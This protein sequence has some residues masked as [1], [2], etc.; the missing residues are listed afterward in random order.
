MRICQ[1]SF[2]AHL[3]QLSFNNFLACF[4]SRHILYLFRIV[5]VFKIA[6]LGPENLFIEL[7]A[8]N[9]FGFFHHLLKTEKTLKNEVKVD[10]ILPF[11][12]PSQS[13]RFKSGQSQKVRNP[14]S[15]KLFSEVHIKRIMNKSN[16]DTLRY[17]G[18]F[19]LLVNKD[20]LYPRYLLLDPFVLKKQKLNQN[21]P[22]GDGPS[23]KQSPFPLSG[24][25]DF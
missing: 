12:S 11:R 19:P 13:V 20:A 15:L 17:Y 10:V 21:Q 4:K 9:F 7:L 22:T 25:I 1:L 2:R 8:E 18:I 14:N 24:R 5:Y 6:E 16:L 3:Q 23:A